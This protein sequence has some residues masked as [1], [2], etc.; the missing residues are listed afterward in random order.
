M[1]HKFTAATTTVL[2]VLIVPILVVTV[3]PAYAIYGV[4][5]NG[6]WPK[7]WPKEMEPLRS[8]A[9]SLHHFQYA[10]H[11]IPFT[12]REGFEAAWPHILA[13]K[14]KEA[15]LILLSG[16]NNYRN[17]GVTIKAGVR[18]RSP[19]TRTLATPHPD[20]KPLRIGPPWPDHIKSESGAL[21]EY[22]VYENGKWRPYVPDAKKD[23]SR[24]ISLRRARIEIELIVDGEV[25]DLNRIPLPAD[26]PIIDKRVSK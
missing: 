15:P 5:E 14:S 24:L 20:G 26:T 12:S 1:R 17:V 23:P 22:V 8:Q 11:D 9:R 3:G 18:I 25:V 19:Q 21:P 10:I 6:S 4:T 7:S 16:P 13:V 2:L